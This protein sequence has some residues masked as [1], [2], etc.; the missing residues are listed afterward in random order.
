MLR[1]YKTQIQSKIQFR[2][3][4]SLALALGCSICFSNLTAAQEKIDL[5]V[6]FPKTKQIRVSSNY[7]HVGDVLVITD[8]VDSK[9]DSKP[10]VKPLR[11]SVEAK[12]TYVQ[13]TM[14]STQTIRYFQNAGA[15]IKLDK[16]SSNPQ[17]KENNRLIVARSKEKSK[18]N[19][20]VEMASVKDTLEQSELDLIQNLSLIHI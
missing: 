3:F 8:P 19:Q 4:F 11:M 5:D 10:G 14:N 9:K 7:E 13:R 16:G 18:G 15:K 12:M 17:L 20:E 2:S 1:P 6:E